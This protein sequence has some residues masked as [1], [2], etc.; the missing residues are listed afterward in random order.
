MIAGSNDFG[1]RRKHP[2]IQLQAYG[3]NHHCQMRV[4]DAP[5][6]AQLI[7]IRPGGARIRLSGPAADFN[8][9][10]GEAVLFD[11]RINGP[12]LGGEIRAVIR[13]VQGMEVGLAFERELALT[14]SDLQRRLTK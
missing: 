4:S 12:G 9:T 5:H 8:P 2:R 14:A 3:F 1:E 6:A 10:R 13:W 11:A 7:A